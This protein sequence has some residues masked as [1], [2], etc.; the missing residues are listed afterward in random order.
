MNTK[1]EA[2]IGFLEMVAIVFAF[3]LVILGIITISTGLHNFFKN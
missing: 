3:W 1:V 2:M